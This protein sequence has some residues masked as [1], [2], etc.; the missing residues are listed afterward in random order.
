MSSTPSPLK[1][2]NE[3]LAKEIERANAYEKS[4]QLEQAKKQWLDIIEYCHLFAKKTADLKPAVVQ[5]ILQKA[6]KLLDRV[7][8]IESKLGGSVSFH[9]ESSGSKPHP[10]EDSPAI[11]DENAPGAGL[12]PGPTIASKP[13]PVPSIAKGDTDKKFINVGNQNIEV[14]DDFPL[15]EITPK[16]SFKPPSVPPEKMEIDKTRF[17]VDDGKTTTAKPA[18]KPPPGK[19]RA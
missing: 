13:A 19:P 3:L 10:T 6:D 18:A 15:V 17:S 16:D 1:K 7:R 5:M 2:F 14:P 9:V 4:G 11:V 8:A 12:Q